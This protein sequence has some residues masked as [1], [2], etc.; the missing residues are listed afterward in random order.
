MTLAVAGLA[1]IRKLRREGPTSEEIAKRFGD[2]G[3]LDR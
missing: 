2:E 1:D 3:S